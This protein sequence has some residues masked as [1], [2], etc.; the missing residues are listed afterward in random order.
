MLIKTMMNP[1]P[2]YM[3]KSYHLFQWKMGSEVFFK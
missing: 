2:K 3:D 1:I